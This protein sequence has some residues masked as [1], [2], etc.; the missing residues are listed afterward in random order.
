MKKKTNYLDKIP[1]YSSEISY[2]A[3]E[4]G[5]VTIQ[6]ENKGTMN[7]LAQIFFKKPRISYIHLDDLG[8][9]VWL[10]IDGKRSVYE[11]AVSVD[12][13]FG[14]KAQ[15]LYERLISFFTALEICKFIIWIK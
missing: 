3:D 7:K 8:S 1:I 2:N 14:E 6:A 5:T 12:D 10:M 11:I 4:N 15:P 13:H 9:F